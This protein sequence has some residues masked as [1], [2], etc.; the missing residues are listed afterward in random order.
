[1]VTRIYSDALQRASNFS[2][3]EAESKSFTIALRSLRCCTSNTSSSPSRPCSEVTAVCCQAQGV[4]WLWGRPS[5]FSHVSDGPAVSNIA[6]LLVSGRAPAVGWGCS[7]LP[8]LAVPEG[9]ELCP[10]SSF[11]A[12]LLLRVPRSCQAGRRYGLGQSR[13]RRRCN[14]EILPLELLVLPAAFCCCRNA[15]PRPSQ[16]SH[17]LAAPIDGAAQLINDQSLARCIG[18][19]MLSARGFYLSP[20]SFPAALPDRLGDGVPQLLHILHASCRSLQ[21]PNGSSNQPQAHRVADALHCGSG[22]SRRSRESNIGTW[23]QPL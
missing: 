23:L 18:P 19:F 2:R 1:M 3:K 17:G 14:H 16:P 8:L 12:V 5:L 10:A 21:T 11:T 22:S 4:L 6:F 13:S 7:Q 9:S 15:S 20:L